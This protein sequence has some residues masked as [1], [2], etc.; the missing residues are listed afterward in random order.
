MVRLV[1]YGHGSLWGEGKASVREFA[2]P[3]LVLF[4]GVGRNLGG[5]SWIVARDG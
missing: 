5:V 3:Q 4:V 2:L 1:T